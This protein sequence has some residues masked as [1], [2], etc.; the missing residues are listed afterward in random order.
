MASLF[1]RPPRFA[2]D[3]PMKKLFDLKEWFT[4]EEAARYLSIVF[5]EVIEQAD[6]LR[7]ALDGHLKL[8]VNFVNHAVGRSGHVVKLEDAKMYVMSNSLDD[9]PSMRARGVL[10][11]ERD[12]LPDEIRKGLDDDTLYFLP[13]GDQINETEWLQYTDEIVR[14]TN[15]WDLS[16]LGAER[17]DVEHTYQQLTGGPEV[18]LVNLDG[19]LMQAPSGEFVR[20]QESYDDNEYQKG[21]QA[22]LEKL[23]QRIA[24]DDTSPEQAE[25]M[26]EQHSRDRKQFLK[27]QDAKPKVD[28][29]YPAGG[30]PRDSVLVVRTTS[31]RAF[32]RSLS[33][34]N[35]KGESE[36]TSNERISLLV[37]IAA[38]CSHSGIELD[39]RGVAGRIERMTQKIG[40]PV[41]ADTIRRVMT[42]ITD[43]V[44]SRKK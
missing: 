41:S 38:I 15:V 34:D 6:V 33:D 10:M 4:V 22:D 43:A 23:K 12:K 24:M 21:S 20:L 14:L 1:F 8:S 28:R 7:L 11:D 36:L 5:N 40:A 42:K 9:F 29:Y 3:E 25:E 32:E 17:L 30:L 26:L 27:K 31:L 2:E 44:E 13:M 39:E 16:M 19:P 37:I 18:T 35:G